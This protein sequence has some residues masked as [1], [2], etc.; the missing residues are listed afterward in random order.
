M[1]D[2]KPG[3]FR[4]RLSMAGAGLAILGAINL[5]FILVA[6]LTAER[7]R[8]YMG[9]FYLILPVVIVLGL[10]LIP[11]GMLLER[12]RRR[13]AAS[14][15]IPP[16]PRIDFNNPQHRKL[17]ALTVVA[18]VVI[19]FCSGI[20]TYKAYELTDSVTFCGQ[21][22]HTPMHPEFTAYQV[23]PHARVKCTECHVGSGAASYAK[24]K[25]SGVHRAYATFLNNFPRPILAP[26]QSLRPAT[27]TCE[28]CHWPEK[29]HGDQ[30]K[31]FNH[32]SYDEQNTA[33][34]TRMLI[35]TGGGAPDSGVNSGIHWH[36]N[37]ANDISYIATDERRQSI[38][39]VRLKDA[40]GNVTEYKAQDSD[41]KPEDI[42]R[43]T[44]RKMDCMDCHNR[45]AHS[46]LPP[47]RAVDEAL[48]AGRL[49]ASLPY[50]KQQAVE[51]VA[52]SYSSVDEARSSIAKTVDDYYKSN[53]A[54][55]YAAKQDSIKSAISEIQNIY[56]KNFFPLMKVDWQTYSDNIG[57]YYTQG[58]FRCHDGQHISSDGKVIRK[59]C[60]IC[61]SVLDQKEGSAPIM[62]RNGTAFQHPID[63][64]DLTAVN[65]TDCHTGRGVGQ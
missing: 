26:V 25:F 59:D 20:G 13:K 27:E 38:A 49:D 52:K 45:S 4:N 19:L 41:F 60:T 62:A 55:R 32:F 31:E 7:P 46:F 28:Q 40:S 14:A 63:L 17:A 53:Y 21:T 22:C 47:D 51:A 44:V 57:H 58:C 16:Y 6:D 2:R 56:E 36:M 12:R 30:L 9:I 35:H 37:I 10:L 64:G 8:P 33:R 5:A 3:L 23:S 15:E 24:S 50:I 34:Q 29:Y 54:D 48:A 65:C 43:A 1:N 18:T 42:A 61:H 39:W 11:I